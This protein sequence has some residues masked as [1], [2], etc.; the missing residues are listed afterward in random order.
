MNFISEDEY[1]TLAMLQYIY[2]SI[3]S[4]LNESGEAHKTVCPSCHVDDFSH[5]EGCPIIS[6]I[7]AKTADI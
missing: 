3:A 1:L 6:K 2:C 7:E 4:T 5:M